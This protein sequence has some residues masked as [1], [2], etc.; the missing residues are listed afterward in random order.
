MRSFLISMIGAIYISLGWL[1]KQSNETMYEVVLYKH[2]FNK[3]ILPEYPC[4]KDPRIEHLS[5]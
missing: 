3:V 1:L 2:L 5:R 4:C